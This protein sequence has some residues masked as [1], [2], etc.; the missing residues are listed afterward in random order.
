MAE[1]NPLNNLSYTNKDFQSIYPELLNVVK[2]LSY[3][4]DPTV[5]NESDPGVLLLKL[6]AIIADKNDYNID[7]NVLE[8][9]PVS[10]TQDSNAR[11]IFEQLGYI[12]HWYIGAATT[13]NM[14]W[15]GELDSSKIY[16]IPKF[17]MVTDS[18][19]QVVYTIVDDNKQ[20]KADGKTVTFNAVQGV[21][22]EYTI[23]GSNLVTVGSLDSENRIYLTELNVAENGIFICNDGAQNYEDW[24]RVDNLASENIA[25]TTKKLYRFGVTQQGDA[26]YIEFPENAETLIGQGINITYIQTDGENGNVAKATIDKLYNGFVKISDD[27]T[28]TADVLQIANP[29]SAQNGES[30]ETIESAYRNYKRNIGTFNTLVT[31]RD[32]NNAVRTSGLISNGFVCDRTNDIQSS[33]DIIYQ[34]G[35]S[36]K[37]YLQI[38]QNS[39]HDVLTAFDLKMYVLEN[40]STVETESDY[41][42]SFTM[43]DNYVG[44]VSPVID[45][46]EDYM[47]DMKTISHD[48]RPLL[49]NKICM[50]KNK[51]PIKCRII[52]Q[53]KIDESQEK[54][55][56]DNVVNALYNNLNSKKLEFGEEVS[57]DMIYDTILTADERIKAITLDDLIF[58][59]YAVYYDSDSDS[60]KYK[61]VKIDELP[62]QQVGTITVTPPTI[63]VGDVTQNITENGY[64]TDTSTDKVYVYD[65]NAGTLAEDIATE[66]AN[67]IY[68]KSVLCGSSQLLEPDKDFNYALNQNFSSIIKDIYKIDTNVDIRFVSADSNNASYTMRENESIFLFAPNLVDDTQYSTYTKYQFNITQDI[69]ANADYMLGQSEYI[70]FYWKEVDDAT[71]P[72]YYAYYGEGAIISP[73]MR[74]LRSNSEECYIPSPH[75]KN[76]KIE[77]G[78]AIFEKISDLIS[79]IKNVLATG[80]A[81]KIRKKAEFI[82][83]NN[84]VSYKCYWILNNKRADDKYVLFN[85]GESIYMLQSG[86]YFMYTED[87]SELIVLGSGTQIYRS[88]STGEWACEA[89]SAETVTRNGIYALDDVWFTIPDGVSVTATEM[90]YYSLGKGTEVIL[91]RKD[92]ESGVDFLF[93]S[94]GTTGYIKLNSEPGDWDENY[95]NY[96]TEND[97]VY[98]HIPE[99][100]GA[101]GFNSDESGYIGPYYSSATLQDFNISYIDTSG[102]SPI[103]IEDVNLGDD[104]GWSGKSVYGIS[105]SP[106]TPQEIKDNQSITVYHDDTSTSLECVSDPYTPLYVLSDYGYALSGGKNIDV[107]R[108]TGSGSTKYMNLYTYYKTNSVEGVD[109]TGSD[110][111]ITLS[112]DSY[113]KQIEFNLPSGKYIVPLECVSEN[114][115]ITASLSYGNPT[116]SQNLTPIYGDIPLD[117]TGVYYLNMEIPSGIENGFTLTVSG[118]TLLTEEP[119]DWS[120]NWADYYI[121]DGENYVH[122]SGDSAPTFEQN[123]YYSSVT[124]DKRVVIHQ[125]LK[126][127]I[128][129]N[130][131]SGRYEAILNKMFNLDIKHKFDYTYVVS[132]DDVITNPIDPASLFRIN[133]P[134][135]EFTI[136]QNNLGKNEIYLMNK[137]R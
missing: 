116:T 130:L 135:N 103:S 85:S 78:S 30:P 81:I 118:Y 49:S 98:E 51:Y 1:K 13:I 65:S 3:K 22:I 7:K 8:C 68:A 20:L 125:L 80:K 102:G 133:H 74:L 25:D 62:P 71:A 110:V 127:S 5:S 87:G 106:T 76:G 101:P 37:E 89:V 47:S 93:D 128:P 104:D 69:E 123:T 60:K 54:S 23:N 58:E 31:L 73:S 48:F 134:Y 109:F 67:E 9:F 24:V 137:V 52:P 131:G 43:A 2:K 10:V 111:I 92:G 6:C 129:E 112:P 17:T 115:V 66:F 35:D 136:C 39:G 16:T 42:K 84:D 33:Y 27:E 50:I 46:L 14:R 83:A 45:N 97:G 56:R 55:I 108:Q 121:K 21:A 90:R 105:V 107:T 34:D 38:E 18:D 12:M 41:V 26:C 126:Y 29:S 132:E 88:S 44:D 11:Q 59:T 95:T 15:V 113:S 100:T 75:P 120:T 70:V 99:G 19:G 63:T 86:E 122:V 36:Y 53:Y 57:Y 64:Y 82:I 79:P 117:S 96:Y 32:Y 119:S 124:E 61:E 94:N 72:Y 40:I 77:I 114:M 28:L 4:W 91:T